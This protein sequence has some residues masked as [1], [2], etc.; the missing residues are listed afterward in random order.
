MHFDQSELM[1]NAAF[2]AGYESAR[3]AEDGLHFDGVEVD[4]EMFRAE[5]EQMS[6]ADRRM[7]MLGTIFRQ[8]DNSLPL[9]GEALK[10]AFMELQQPLNFATFMHTAF[11]SIVEAAAKYGDQDSDTWI[12]SYV[13]DA[14]LQLLPVPPQM[15][16]G[17][18]LKVTG[19]GKEGF[20]VT[21]NYEYN[22]AELNDLL[23]AI[24]GALDNILMGKAQQEDDQQDDEQRP[25]FIII[26]KDE[27]GY[28]N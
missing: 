2:R 25:P 6:E 21:I 24:R 19:K 4:L 27:D 11:A 23:G 13:I 7:A 12:S 14:A 15:I 10:E 16:K 5:V 9:M 3:R 26:P 17:G 20:T 18:K 1:K 8:I 22:E 28:L